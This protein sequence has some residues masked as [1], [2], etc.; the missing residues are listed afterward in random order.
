[1]SNTGFLH[2]FEKARAR[3]RAERLVA[4][5]TF[6]EKALELQHWSLPPVASVD[7]LVARRSELSAALEKYAGAVNALPQPRDRR[8][9]KV[10]RILR[11][12]V[13][14]RRGILNQ[15][16]RLGQGD[17]AALEAIA[18]ALR[19]WKESG[20]RAQG[21]LQDYAAEV[22]A[23]AGKGNIDESTD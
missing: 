6:M 1:M 7:E 23:T 2:R 14:L 15:I 19:L 20:S 11:W 4:D 17:V 16:A 8:L 9:W 5:K 12:G 22:L 13:D 21:L 18:K 10:N 3:C